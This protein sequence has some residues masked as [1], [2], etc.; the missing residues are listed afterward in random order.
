M[1]GIT[2][3]PWLRWFLAAYA[4]SIAVV[5]IALGILTRFNAFLLAFTMLT[6]MLTKV[7]WDPGIERLGEL[8][9][10]FFIFVA[11]FSILMSGAGKIFNNERFVF[12]KK[13]LEEE[14]SEEN[15]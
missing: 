9:A 3:F 14:V 10:A 6:A 1:Y 12:G 5:L 4:E 2:F 13:A 15:I 11:A 8:S 7:L